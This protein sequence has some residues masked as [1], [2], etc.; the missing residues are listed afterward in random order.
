[1]WCLF[2]KQTV[3]RP[4]LLRAVDINTLQ[5]GAEESPRIPQIPVL[6]DYYTQSVCAELNLSL[7]SYPCGFLFSACVCR[8]I[9]HS[10][11]LML[12]HGLSSLRMSFWVFVNNLKCGPGFDFTL[13]F[14]ALGFGVL[15]SPL[16]S[17]PLSLSF[18]FLLYSQSWFSLVR[19]LS[20]LTSCLSDRCAPVSLFIISN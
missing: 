10:H 8:L 3:K 15:F 17:V 2:P 19:L 16:P 13:F 20:V 5:A 6:S 18:Y 14:L 12:T 9:T 4:L 1:M 11:S 7:R